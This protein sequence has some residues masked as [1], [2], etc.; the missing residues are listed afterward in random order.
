[1]VVMVCYVNVV[2]FVYIYFGWV[3]DFVVSFI[4]CV[5]LVYKVVI[6]VKNLI[7]RNISIISYWGGDIY[8]YIYSFC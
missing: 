8:I 5:K 1:M 2:I 4:L 7:N 3:L 6:I